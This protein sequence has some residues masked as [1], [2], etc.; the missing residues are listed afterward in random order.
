MTRVI[1]KAKSVFHYAS[2]VGVGLAICS[3]YFA[4]TVA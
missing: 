1:K 2:A 4:S 3:A